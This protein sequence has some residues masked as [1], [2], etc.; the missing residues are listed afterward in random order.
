M[1]LTENPQHNGQSNS[2]V[3]HKS[4]DVSAA[5]NTR[6]RALSVNS[7]QIVRAVLNNLSWRHIGWIGFAALFTM[8]LVSAGQFIIFFVYADGQADFKKIGR[9]MVWVFLLFSILY[10]LRFMHIAVTWKDGLKESIEAKYGL[11]ASETAT[12]VTFLSRIK[13][14]TAYYNDNFDINGKYY[15]WILYLGKVMENWVQFTNILQVY[16]CTL[17]VGWNL[18]FISI[19]IVESLIQCN[20]FY[21]KVCSETPNINI[22]ERNV[23]VILDIGIDLF[24]LFIPLAILWFGFR[25]PASISEII[26]IIIVPSVSLFLK[27]PTIMEQ[28]VYN[29]VNEEIT[30]QQINKSKS[31]KRRRKSLFGQAVNKQVIELQNRYF[32]RAA[33][34]AMFILSLIY[35]IVL[36]V[37]LIGQLTNLSFQDR[38]NGAFDYTSTWNGC[39]IKI[40]FCKRP[41][42][43]KCNCAYLHIEND[44]TL[45]LPQK[46]TTEMDGLRKVHITNSNLTSLPDNMENLIE[47]RDFEIAF[48]KLTAFN[49]D[50]RK[51][52]N[53]V[54]LFL[55]YNNIR[56]YNEEAVWTHP[57]IVSLDFGDNVGLKMP[58]ADAKISMP[59]LQYLNTMN[60]SVSVNTI[61]NSD[62]FPRLLFLYISGNDLVTFPDKSMKKTIVKL[63]IARCNLFSLPNYLHEFDKL[64]YL[65]VR[66]NNI[67][68]VDSK[69]I[70]LIKTKE[71][72]T[73]FAGNEIACNEHEN[74]DCEPLC[75]IYCSRRTSKN[76]FCNAECN[77]KECEYDGGDC[78]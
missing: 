34:M 68:H 35:T 39:A 57:T 69:L 10:F 24:F 62:N 49:V 14:A 61:F 21:R 28:V 11:G 56:Q 20:V 41:F 37:L 53:I 12:D 65:D 38:C 50:V 47:M 73:Y 6:K 76:N 64:Q 70:S 15:L 13:V 42:S 5:Y 8:L 1:E 55:T 58:G 72:E 46:I 7:K 18:V 67:S 44:Y 17:P 29:R 25:V 27:L 26:R 71:M 22:N 2:D 48:T 52:E 54:R 63:T 33:K 60:N 4:T 30:G 74:L 3:D 43:P 19:L 51:W 16:S 45:I 23:Q 40:P 36:S 9:P 66:Y 32:S 31:L 75:S 78:A 59:S 77:S